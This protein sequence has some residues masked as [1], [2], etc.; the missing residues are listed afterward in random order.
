[1]AGFP[2]TESLPALLGTPT[3]KWN[4]GAGSLVIRTSRPVKVR[5]RA[6]A[7]EGQ[8]GFCLMR[9]DYGGAVSNQPFIKPDQ[10]DT[11]VELDFLPENSPARIALY[12]HNDEGVAGRVLLGSVIIY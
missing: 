5:I 6:Q 12:N 1:V 10:G 4:F 2:N 11:A 7:L 3:D 9:E 8:I